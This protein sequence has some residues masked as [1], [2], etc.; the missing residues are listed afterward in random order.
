VF[1]PRSSDGHKRHTLVL[2]AVVAVGMPGCLLTACSAQSANQAE[3]GTGASAIAPTTGTA[4]KALRGTRKRSSSP[5]ALSLMSRA[6]QAAVSTSY[7]GEE[8]DIGGGTTLVSDIWHSSGGQTKTQ[9]LAAGTGASNQPYVSTDP[10]GN[11]PEGVLGVTMTLVQL[12]ET[13][14][15]VCYVGT[16]SA[17]KRAAQVVEAWRS[18]GSLAARFWIDTETSLPL[19]R[20]VFDPSAHIT[21]EDYFNI[22]RIGTSAT[23]PPSSAGGPVAS[24]EELA[25]AAK[26]SGQPAWSFPIARAKLL[27]FGQ[28]GWKVPAAL[29]DGLTLFTGGVTSLKSGIM[30]DLSYSDGL[31]VVTL[32]EQRGKLAAKLAGWQRTMVGGRAIYTVEPAQRLLTWAGGGVVYT[33]I[34]DAPSPTVAKVVKTLPYDKPPGF[35]K[36]MSRGLSRLASLMN[37]FR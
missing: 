4:A 32:F 29:P 27:A 15:V 8:W 26:A 33:V 25:P 14:Y 24:T 7:T 28:A 36:R 35:W 20:Q 21:N 9:T 16:A 6:A 1:T 11:E 5:R 12:L 17:S 3:P 23:P 18:D 2:A 30:L 13:H 34:A 22:V 10:M 19:E 37:P 31:Y